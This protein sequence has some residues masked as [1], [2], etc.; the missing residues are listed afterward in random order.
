MK[1]WVLFGG[2][3][4]NSRAG[5]EERETRFIFPPLTRWNET[6]RVHEK[7]WTKKANRTPLVISEAPDF[8]WSILCI[9]YAVVFI[10]FYLSIHISFP[11]PFLFR[12]KLIASSHLFRI[13]SSFPLF[14]FL[15][16][17]MYNWTTNIY[18]HS[19]VIKRLIL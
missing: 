19:S 8:L 7:I 11:L 10:P 12:W 14:F 18:N 6:G 5:K 9:A 13:A 4:R 15:V 1:A 3:L 16:T 2:C 17:K